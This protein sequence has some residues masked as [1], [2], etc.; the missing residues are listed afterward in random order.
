MWLQ[1]FSLIATIHLFLFLKEIFHVKMLEVEYENNLQFYD[2][3]I[4]VEV[5][6]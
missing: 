3:Y 5:N 4:Y 6:A 2:T 1:V